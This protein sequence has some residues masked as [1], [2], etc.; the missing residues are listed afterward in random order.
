[1]ENH[2]LST[3]KRAVKNWWI[4]LLVG[5][6]AVVV[7]F[8]CMFTPFATFA[9]ITLLFVF[10]FFVG[11]I[12][13]IVFALS[14]KNVIHNWGWT[15]A[16]GII[17]LLFA[18]FL[19]ANL[20]IAPLMLC[21]FIAFWI[22]IQ[23][24]WGIGMAFDL[25]SVRNSGWGWVLALSILSVFASIILLFQPAIAGLFAAYIISFAFIFYGILRIFLAFK[26]KTLVKYLP[27]DHDEHR[28]GE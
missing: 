21:Y 10:S 11:G 17:D 5:I 23:S 14:N 7:G 8:I 13:E 26:L 28:L 4:S 2:L 6:V 3:F 27:K 24:I 25:Q 9:A 15:L 16:M 22:L 20:D 19:L 12:S 1:M 18:V